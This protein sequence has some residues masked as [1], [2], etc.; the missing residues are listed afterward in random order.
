MRHLATRIHSVLLITALLS[1]SVTVLPAFAQEHEHSDP[2]PA[3]ARLGAVSFEI[4]C[5]AQVQPEFNRAVAL[6]HSFWH[7]EAQRVFEN[8][9]RSDPN[10]AMAYWGVA[11]S[12]FHL[13]LSWPA[14][15][16]IELGRQALT[17]AEAAAEKD[18]REAAY[19]TALRELYSDFK[20][21]D[22][23][24]YFKSY[25]D[26]L[27]E[28]AAM[29]PKDLEARVFEGLALILAQRP[30]D[31]KLTE[32]KQ[33][34]NLLRPLLLQYPDHPGIAHYLIH[35]CDTPGLAQEGLE[36]ARRYAKIAPAAPH[37]L[38]MPSHI[39]T[40]LGLWQE[41]IDSNLASKAAAEKAHAGAENRLHAMEFLEYAYLQTGNDVKA[42]A[43]LAEAKTISKA[44]VDLRYGSYYPTVETRFPILYA[45]ETQDWETAATV[46]SI[47]NEG[48]GR[49]LALLAH[50][51]AAGH[52]KD[53][54]LADATLQASKDWFKQRLK[55]KPLPRSGTPESGFLDL[56]Q[57][58]TD[59]TNGN[60]KGAEDLLHPVADREAQVGKGELD[61]PA[62]EMLA[63]ML[64]L[65]GMYKEALGEYQRSLRS[66]PNRFNAL[67]GAGRAAERLGERDV[68]ANYYRTL[69][70]N[71]AGANGRALETLRHP[72]TVVEAMAGRPA[73]ENASATAN[74]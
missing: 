27:S 13:G 67:L 26:K 57:A 23:W 68:A 2:M 17:K 24:K 59:F 49:A 40:R 25:A 42:Y 39:F 41:D 30:G 72:R 74:H 15:A 18:A 5:K 66:D 4:S 45:V 61:L 50:A 37:A 20:I 46:Q 32:L 47:S 31:V 3:D 48:G 56:I 64:R 54:A 44:D 34:V 12:H 9:A 69:V 60:L 52:L 10:C 21:E 28:I 55:G 53:R 1:P 65:N 70:E 43:I 58:W 38:H 63:D 51:M 22:S 8:V 14:P 71:C 16:D 62:R 7:S 73:Y 29:Y 35:A 36:A 33:A 11:M 6:L 19:I